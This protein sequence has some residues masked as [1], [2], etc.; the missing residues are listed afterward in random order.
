MLR[1]YSAITIGSLKFSYVINCEIRSSWETFTDTAVIYLPNNLRKKNIRIK[2][3]IKVN[4]PVTIK[5]GY[6]PNLVTR[7]TG[8]VSKL[9]N[10]SPLKVMCEDES[11]QL[12]QQF[13]ESYTKK[14]VS[15]E[16]LIKDNYTGEYNVS[17]ADLGGFSIQKGAT[18]IDL[19]QK[20]RSVYKLY[21]WNKDGVLNVG[22]P[23]L[24]AGT[25]KKFHF[26][27]NII[28]GS[29]LEVTDETDL[30]TIAYGVSQQSNGTKIELYTYYENGQIKTSETN[31]TGYLNTMNIPGL[32]KVKLTELLERWLPNLNYTGYKGQF[33]TFGEPA[34]EH[35]DVAEIIDFKYPEKNGKYLIKAVNIIFGQD[36]YRQRIELDKKL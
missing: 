25:I 3:I 26:Q 16:T 34:M 21:S 14:R 31:P 1:L 10:E 35:G 13:L 15:L 29:N 27:K 11:Y 28:N 33:T 7:F 18:M 6:F 5:I 8:Y 2:D 17:D 23:Y 20:L 4:D 36:G 12:K 19:L 9:V 22:L 24:G 30:K 32:T